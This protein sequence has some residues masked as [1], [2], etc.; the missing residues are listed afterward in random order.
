MA[1][2]AAP[3]LERHRV[4]DSHDAEETREFLRRK[5]YR[6]DL[7][8]RQSTLLDTRLNAFYM[9][10]MYIGYMH[11]GS[12]P[13]TLSPSADRADYLVQL[14]LRGH[15][16]ASIG[17]EH[18]DGSRDRAAVA[19]PVRESCRFVS[20][21]DSARV[22]LA[23][24]RPAL[25]GQLAALL[26]EPPHAPLDF[27]PAID[28]TCGYGR[29]LAQF[30]LMAAADLDRLDSVLSNPITMSI[31]EQF[32]MTGMLLS[33]SHNYS[34]SLQRCERPLAPRDVK[35]ALDYLEANLDAPVTLAD[36]VAVTGVSG[37][38]LFKHFRDIRG[39]SPMRYLRNARFQKAR[40]ALLKS[41]PVESITAIALRCGFNHLGRFSVEYRKRFGETPSQTLRGRRRRS[42]H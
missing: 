33:H 27:A 28:L 26:G 29:S 22:Q 30:V 25:V 9:P 3:L 7:S 18:V 42:S 19:S 17:G 12:L 4:F 37:R 31:F 10:G 1:V 6:F 36:L 40:E 8:P 24:S 38:T 14:P 20:S 35:R 34:D 13:V 23:L 5:N 39:V 2:D 11:Y 16:A 41:E 15:L 32:I 21:A